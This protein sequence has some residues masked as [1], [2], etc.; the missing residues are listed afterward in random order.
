MLR[1]RGCT[2]RMIDMAEIGESS[3]S[4]RQLLHIE[5]TAPRGIR[6]KQWQSVKIHWCSKMIGNP[7]VKTHR[8][9]E[10]L[11]F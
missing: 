6:Q 3:F 11:F 1:R 8:M 2:K 5:N 9:E 7:R 10:D 4:R